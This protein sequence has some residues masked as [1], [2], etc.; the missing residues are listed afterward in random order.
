MKQSSGYYHIPKEKRRQ[1]NLKLPRPPLNK[2][3]L[4]NILIC[5]LINNEV[6]E[7]SH[8]NIRLFPPKTR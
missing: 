8:L 7:F 2:Y 4:N 5:S 1:C 3:H 6:S